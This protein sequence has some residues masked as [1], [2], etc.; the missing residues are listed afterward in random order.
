MSKQIWRGLSHVHRRQE[1]NHRNDSLWVNAIKISLNKSV[2]KS[3][4]GMEFKKKSANLI[5]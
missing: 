4:S 5:K 2:L 1:Q 3:D